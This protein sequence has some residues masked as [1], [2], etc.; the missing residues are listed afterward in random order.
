MK[1]PCPR[2]NS[3][4]KWGQQIEELEDGKICVF[5]RCTKCR[6]KIVLRED[7]SDIISNEREIER[8]KIR[9]LKDP[10]LNQIIRRK[11]Q[12]NESRKRRA[13]S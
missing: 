7:Y 13:D 12:R 3:P 2:C 9:A 4:Q 11:R 8:L 1:I 5:I 10:S 6:Y